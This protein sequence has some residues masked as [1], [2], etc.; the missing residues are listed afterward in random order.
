MRHLPNYLIRVR[1]GDAYAGKGNWL[2]D[3][4]VDT[5][6][7]AIRWYAEALKEGDDP[8]LYTCSLLM[9]DDEQV[10]K[11]AERLLSKPTE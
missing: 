7:E 10:R 6:D 1:V 3:R 2:S 5:W 8:T 11:Q 4:Y 9:V